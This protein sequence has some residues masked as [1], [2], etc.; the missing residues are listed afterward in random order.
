MS[1]GKKTRMN[2]L[3]DNL[4]QQFLQQGYLIIDTDID[5]SVLDGAREDLAPFFGDDRQ[6]P[7]NVPHA[8][9]NRIQD[10]WYI[11][12]HVLK[13]AQSKQVLDVLETL[14][15]N[16]ARPFQ[17]INFYKGTQQPVHADSIHFNSEPFGSMCGVWVALEDI[18]PDQGPLIYYPGSQ[19]LDEMNYD[20]FKLASYSKYYPQYLS[21]LQDVIAEHGF[22]PEHGIIKKGQA[23]IWSA[24]IIHGGS[25]QRD[26]SLT[27]HSQVTHYYMR[28]ARYWRPGASIRTRNYFEPDWVR[29]VSG[30]PNRFPQRMPFSERL[31][32]ALERRLYDRKP[33]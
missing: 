11:S 23:V 26:M 31:K 13:I 4:K 10:A 33:G 3:E 21:G 20:F 8:E 14:Y 9:P 25:T 27:R 29:D 24:N 22:T 7:I 28:G 6:D 12:Q 30:E 19:M 5:V 1:V 32:G 2:R 15:E 18:G 16:E 17:T